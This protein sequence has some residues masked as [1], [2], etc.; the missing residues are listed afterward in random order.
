[1]K[2][3]NMLGLIIILFVQTS[4][5]AFAQLSVPAVDL[6]GSGQERAEYTSKTVSITNNGDDTITD[7][8]VAF[9]SVNS[10]Y[11]VTY[12][13]S[14]NET[15]AGASV[16]LTVTGYVPLYFDAVNSKGQ[17][18]AFT[19]GT[20]KVDA[21]NDSN[22]QSLSF[23]VSLSM[24]A[25]NLLDFS[26]SDILYVDNDNDDKDKS[27]DDGDSFSEVRRDQD[28]TISVE[29]ENKFD[30]DGDCDDPDDYGDCTIEDVEIE[31]E[32]DDSDFDDDTFD[33]GDV[34]SED[35]E[36][37]SFSF[38]IPDDVDEDNFDFEL[39][40]IGDDENGA[41]H[42]E[43]LKFTLEVE[44]PRDQITIKDAYLNPE[45]IDCDQGHVT[46]RVNVENTGSR[47]QDEVVI[48][49]K[50]D[51]LGVN[52][53]SYPD[54]IDLEEEDD[55]TESFDISLPED[56]NPGLYNFIVTSYYDGD[57]ESDTESISLEIRECEFDFD[58]D[59]D[60]DVFD[61]D[62]DDEFDDD[63][64][65]TDVNIIEVPPSTGVIYGDD[66]VD[67]KVSF[68][69]TPQYLLLLGGLFLFALL[70]FFVLLVVLLRR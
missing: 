46:L 66:K 34:D 16:D 43:Y 57:E 45:S 24:E 69:D 26:E 36:A 64:S 39:W 8:E 30:N 19:L 28:V 54:Y 18:V 56:V 35:T 10:D 11:D 4:V 55:A 60:D 1:M 59:D 9:E 68:Y 14:D 12:T 65:N 33:V 67:E 31:F 2:K 58:D 51:R 42:G 50:S 53:L 7:I 15:V 29:V 13:L 3:T 32:P 23:E 22:G 61:D 52:M 5:S 49:V 62:D 44:V 40:V 70:I 6:G 17:K 20:V 38:D 25:E 41:R 37:E 47:D 27:L 63:D 48:K 21:I